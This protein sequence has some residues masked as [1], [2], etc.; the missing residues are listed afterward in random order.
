[1]IHRF[2]RTNRQKTRVDSAHRA[3]V[4]PWLAH[5]LQLADLNRQQ[6]H[7]IGGTPSTPL[8]LWTGDRLVP[9]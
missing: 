1:M 6:V 5:R 3:T 7:D 2:W 9:R 8:T 4:I